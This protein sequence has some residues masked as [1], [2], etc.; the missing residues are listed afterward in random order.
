MK[1]KISAIVLSILA[2][3]TLSFLL[4]G[5]GEK[6]H[7]HTYS[8]QWSYDATYH[9]HSAIC[10]HTEEVKD[11]E[12]HEFIDD[13]CIVCGYEKIV[14][15]TVT[16]D[17]NGGEFDDGDTV[18]Y[19]V[20]KGDL[21][22]APQTPNYKGY[23]FI[24]WSLSSDGEQLWDFESDTVDQNITLFAIW[25][26]DI[27]EYNVTFVLNYDDAQNVVMSTESGLVTYIPSRKGYIFNGWWLSD[28]QTNNGDYIL[29]EKWD[30]TRLVEQEGLTL[31]AE[32]VEESTQS[33]QLQAPCVT[34]S[35]DVFSWEKISGAVKYDI[36]LYDENATLELGAFEVSATTW[37]FPTQINPGY[38]VIKIRAIGDGINNI[39]SV[40]VTKNYAYHVLNAITGV[41]FDINTSLLTWNP[42][43]NANVYKIYLHGVL[44]QTLTYTTYDMSDLDA[45]TY[46]FEIVAE[47]SGYLSSSV[48][49]T[50][51]KS[52]LKTPINVHAFVN[53]DGIGYTL[54]WDS[55]YHANA[56]LLTLNGHEIKI[57][58]STSYVLENS[59]SFW[60]GEDIIY[61]TVRA[62]DTN[63]DYLVS[64]ST[65]SYD[66]EKVYSLSI[67][68]SI[69]DA[70]SVEVSGEM[71][72]PRTY[73]VSFETKG[74]GTI[75]SQ[76][77][78]AINAIKYPSTIPM[79][80]GYVFTGWYK[81]YD[82]T[83]V[84]DFQSEI[85]Q[86]ITLYAG[87][88]QTRNQGMAIDVIDITSEHNSEQD[89]YTVFTSGLDSDYAYYVY[90]TALT[91]GQYTFNYK[92]SSSSSTHATNYYIY[93]DITKE[94]IY[95]G[96][97]KTTS[98]SSKS[99]TLTAGTVVYI[100]I[101]PYRTGYS[102]TFSFYI[103]GGSLPTDGGLGHYDYLVNS[104]TT[105]KLDYA[106]SYLS[107]GNTITLT[108]NTNLGYTWVGWFLN[109]DLLS[110]ELTYNYTMS[111]GNQILTAKWI[112]VDTEMSN[113]SAGTITGLDKSFVTGEQATVTAHTNSGYT[114]VGW[115]QGSNLLTGSATYVFDMPNQ[116][117][118]LLAKWIK[119]TVE[120]N[121][122][123]CGT[124]TNLDDTYVSGEQ[125]TITAST[126]DGYTFVGWYNG[127]TL[128]TNQIDYTFNMPEEDV[129]YTAKWDINYLDEQGQFAHVSADELTTIVDTETEILSGWCALVGTQQ[130]KTA[131]MI[132]EGEVYL[133]LTNN[134][135][136]KIANLVVTEGNEIHIYAQSSQS[137]MGQLTVVYNIGGRDG[138][139]GLPAYTYNEEV[140]GKDGENSGIITINGGTIVATKIGGGNGGTGATLY[141]YGANGYSGGNGG[142]SSS[143]IINGGIIEATSIGAGNGGDGG[144]GS[145]GEYSNAYPF[146]GGNGGKGGNGG[147]ATTIVFNGGTI[148]VQNVGA[149]NGGNG[150]Y[151][152]AG[153]INDSNDPTAQGG[154]GGNGANG[155]N[156]GSG[157]SILIATD[158]TITAHVGGGL[159][160]SAG[161][162]GPGGANIIKQGPKGQDGK[163]GQDGGPIEVFFLGSQAE[164]EEKSI[165]SANLILY[166][167][168]QDLPT[169][170]GKYWH[171]DDGKNI[172]KW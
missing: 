167:Y 168:S 133:I 81:D 113:L 91:S 134:C 39:N 163:D 52:R 146:R 47:R 110:N 78:S 152:G 123:H 129:T 46:N 90:F 8:T 15:L 169:N 16:F 49:T 5:C 108:A 106:T 19:T 100:E 141:G 82:C 70:G 95:S 155:G 18:S 30:T 130:S 21:I 1:Q 85:T 138:E 26:K 125:I 25:Q 118:T 93:N 143:I 56:Y 57:N 28:G 67:S 109:D 76:E 20:N 14:T 88:Q 137:N 27:N 36:R 11:K 139:D 22:N 162:G 145:Q 9:W 40:Y 35:A 114:W 99:F 54:M 111:K 41:K 24:G 92:N 72:L 66:I 116:N 121:G 151:G 105:E 160:G 63:G 126:N 65:Q 58:N 101:T 68:K 62:F 159:A 124:V 73:R 38:Y 79:K 44:I 147:N 31:Y 142:N 104:T 71:Y 136:W 59:A 42:V 94:K 74:A 80:N 122:T 6:E 3:F 172:V 112:K 103:S 13:K 97:A 86:D 132:V 37:S 128:I 120:M 89:L 64:N 144:T 17:A 96:T 32:W 83:Q 75:Q 43:K 51:V 171:Y 153:G 33:T 69:D 34:V 140:D 135:Q 10:E 84:Y 158:V 60:D 150:G 77:V 115:Y 102:A 131:N 45:N 50:V 166:I 117:T 7:I 170:D 2:I 148:S 149:G 98:F 119:V 157:E 48:T 29:T 4:V 164:W 55:V 107:N 12:M 127:Q 161:Y 61:F 23:S 154:T 87:W 156:G 53:G 165:N